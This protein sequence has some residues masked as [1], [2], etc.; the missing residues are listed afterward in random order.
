METLSILRYSDKFSFVMIVS[1]LLSQFCP[2][3]LP[4]N[5]FSVK[6]KVYLKITAR[7][8]IYD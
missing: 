8:I 2:D 6:F 1:E 4:I 3:N 7:Q 5:L